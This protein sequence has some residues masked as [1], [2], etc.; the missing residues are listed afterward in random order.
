MIIII[1]QNYI[2]I[3]N[4]NYDYF[5]NLPYKYYYFKTTAKIFLLIAT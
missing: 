5:A 3:I 2:C 1:E 4:L